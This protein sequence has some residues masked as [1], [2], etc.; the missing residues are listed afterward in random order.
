MEQPHPGEC[1]DHAISVTA[2]NDRLI[3]DR[4]TRF[5]DIT[6]AAF[7]GAFNI[8]LKGEESVRTQ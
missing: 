2:I 3:A 4:T 7:L 6:H 1:H 5:R 8:V